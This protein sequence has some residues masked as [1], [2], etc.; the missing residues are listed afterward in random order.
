VFLN[1]RRW[2]CLLT[3]EE[4]IKKLQED[5][6]YT[7]PDEATDEEWDIYLEAKNEG[8]KENEEDIDE[9]DE[10]EETEEEVPEEEL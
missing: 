6:S 7:L 1:F 10:I 3:K 8:K 9:R 5:P 2:V 4:I